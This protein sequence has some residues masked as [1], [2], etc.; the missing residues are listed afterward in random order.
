MIP[1]ALPGRVTAAWLAAFGRPPDAVSAFDTE[2][3]IEGLALYPLDGDRWGVGVLEDAPAA[4]P[5]EVSEEAARPVS[6]WN[7]LDD[8][9]FALLQL[10]SA[11]DEARRALAGQPPR[12]ALPPDTT[13]F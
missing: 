12:W 1:A 11:A 6:E 4:V 13:L 8:A 7:T 9:L 5:G 10:A 3:R 2:L